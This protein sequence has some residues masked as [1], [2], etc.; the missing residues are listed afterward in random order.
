ME[1]LFINFN[2]CNFDELSECTLESNVIENINLKTS[3]Y[4]EFGA[5]KAVFISLAHDYVI[6]I[7]FCGDEDYDTEEF[8][9]F[10]CARGYTEWDYCD[11]ESYIYNHLVPE[12]LKILFAETRFVT[13]INDY[14]IYIQPKCIPFD[15]DKF[16]SYESIQKTHE[17]CS[18]QKLKCFNENWLADVYETYGAEILTDLLLFIEEYNIQDL[19]NGNIGYTEEGYPIIFDYSGFNN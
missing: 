14:P 1:E 19:H 6:K 11:A 15:F 3:M 16:Q 7:P 2:K 5:S 10:T 9:S 8:Y 4:Y 18:E 17:I 13:K 12:H